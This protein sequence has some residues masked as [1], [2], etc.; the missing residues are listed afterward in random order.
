MTDVKDE[1]R[2][3]RQEHGAAKDPCTQLPGKLLFPRPWIEPLHDPK[4]VEGGRNVEYLEHYIPVG[5]LEGQVEISRAEHDRIESL[6]YQGHTCKKTR[7]LG[8]SM[9]NG[10]PWTPK[11]LL[12]FRALVTVDRY[13]K[14]A[15][16][17][18]MGNISQNPKDL[19][20]LS[21]SLLL[22]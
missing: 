20:N 19:H 18:E 4:D 6:R 13:H 10:H 17:E 15:F 9:T 1:H 2:N 21:P 22:L 12:T 14:D 11:G 5:S 16:R 8:R 7:Q 3:G